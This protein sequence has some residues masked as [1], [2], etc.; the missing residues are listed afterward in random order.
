VANCWA[1]PSIA[2]FKDQD[3]TMPLSVGSQTL[4]I[5]TL[6][7]PLIPCFAS[8]RKNTGNPIGAV[9]ANSTSKGQV[10]QALKLNRLR[11]TWQWMVEI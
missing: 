4:I 10:N 1:A 9:D 7:F 5:I 3:P 2:G 11:S 8:K 6:A